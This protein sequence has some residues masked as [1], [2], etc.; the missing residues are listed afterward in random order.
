M[1]RFNFW[2]VLVICAFTLTVGVSYFAVAQC[3]VPGVHQKGEP[4]KAG[5]LNDPFE[6]PPQA[7]ELNDN[8]P[9]APWITRWYSLK[10]PITNN[11]GFAASARK[12]W[13]DMGT[14]GKITQETLSTESGLKKTQNTNVNLRN[15]GGDMGWCIIEINPADGN[16]MS[17]AYG[18]VDQ[19][20]IDTYAM[21]VIDSPNKRKAT[22]SPAHDD[23]AQIWLNGDKVYNNSRWTGGATT[24]DFEFEVELKKGANVLLYRCGESG[25]SDYFNLHLDNQ[26]DRAVT[27]FPKDAKDAEEFFKEV[28]GTLAVEPR[29]KLSTTWA[30]IKRLK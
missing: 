26:T 14:N 18:L 28:G 17:T 1:D 3:T 8:R 23:H 15:N 10:G 20:N 24:V 5:P 12:D 25:G 27:I 29:N 6:D 9:D 22:M 16:N 2:A 13:I 11:G 30:N 7:A 19:S 4:L 21:I